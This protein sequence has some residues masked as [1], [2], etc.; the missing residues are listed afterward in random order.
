MPTRSDKCAEIL[1]NFCLRKMPSLPK[2]VTEEADKQR[3]KS[4]TLK[5][6]ICVARHGDRTPKCASRGLR[7]V[8]QFRN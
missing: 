8:Y 5:S 2:P 4:W 7:T 3:E 6:T 1:T